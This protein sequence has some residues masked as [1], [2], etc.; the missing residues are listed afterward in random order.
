MHLT[1]WYHLKINLII[2][3]VRTGCWIIIE[4]SEAVSA[5]LETVSNLNRPK[6]M[7]ATSN[8]IESVCKEYPNSHFDYSIFYIARLNVSIQI[9]LYAP[10][11][12]DHHCLLNSANVQHLSNSKECLPLAKKHLPFIVNWTVFYKIPWNFPNPIG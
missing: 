12:S 1:I 6:H 8:M 11:N 4:M 10:V 7:L 5:T 3:L 9:V 2:S